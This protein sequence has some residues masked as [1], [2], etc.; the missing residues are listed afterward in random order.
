MPYDKFAASGVSGLGR[1]KKNAN[2]LS[3]SGNSH[4]GITK[5][6]VRHRRFEEES[7]PNEQHS[8][9]TATSSMATLEHP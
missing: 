2:V 3:N 8:P 4:N 1:H 7:R 5:F 6:Y 9:S